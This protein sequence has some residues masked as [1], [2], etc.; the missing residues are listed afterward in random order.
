MAPRAA[1]DG[2]VDRW[3]ALANETHPDAIVASGVPAD[4]ITFA[5]RDETSTFMF[6]GKPYTQSD[7]ELSRAGQVE[8]IKSGESVIAKY[9]TEGKD[10]LAEITAEHVARDQE[11]LRRMDEAYSNAPI[12]S[13]AGS[14]PIPSASH[15]PS[16]PAETL[17]K[18]MWDSLDD[19]A[20]ITVYHSTNELAAREMMGH[21][22]SAS[23][24]NIVEG[25]EIRDVF[26]Q[27][28]HWPVCGERSGGYFW[29]WDAQSDD[30]IRFEFV[31]GGYQGAAER[32]SA[33][34]GSVD[35]S[36]AEHGR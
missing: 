24:K 2:T 18:E 5:V 1:A 31:C 27:T 32:H 36:H 17:T 16:I 21:G 34:T 14:E 30:G 23:G 28:R 13:G 7:Y 8:R 12:V 19:N 11:R 3:G 4:N 6:E 22:V 9:R 20:W 35:A 15:T 29:I 10:E 33:S 26:G 25:D